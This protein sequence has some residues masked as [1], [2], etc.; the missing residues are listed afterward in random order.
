MPKAIEYSA[1]AAVAMAQP[2]VGGGLGDYVDAGVEYNGKL[3]DVGISAALAMET[4]SAEGPVTIAGTAVGLDGRQYAGT[5]SGVRTFGPVKLGG[6]VRYA[7]F[8]I[9]ELSTGAALA[10]GSR[11]SPDIFVY[12]VGVNYTMGPWVVAALTSGGKDETRSNSLA[13]GDISKRA[14]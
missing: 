11:N 12:E 3:G 14:Y 8:D 6:A 13:G 10:A 1:T 2:Q 7:Q 4:A 5:A 9:S